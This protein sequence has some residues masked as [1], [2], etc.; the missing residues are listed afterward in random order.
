M[1]T[2]WYDPR[3]SCPIPRIGNSAPRVNSSTAG[4]FGTV[5][6]SEI[7]QTFNF[8]AKRIQSKSVTQITDEDGL[9]KEF[10]Q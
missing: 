3:R 6:R 4:E 1:N 8:Q 9:P 5:T 2:L 7:G 10:G